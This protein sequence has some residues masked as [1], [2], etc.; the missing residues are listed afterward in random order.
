MKGPK[1]WRLRDEWAAGAR[2]LLGHIPS[3]ASRT[4]RGRL[5]S[6]QRLL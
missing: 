6:R 1:A 2:G 4:P 3:D 5:S